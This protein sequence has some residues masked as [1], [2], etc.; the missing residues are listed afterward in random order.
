[1]TQDTG[2]RRE[3]E[4]AH[5]AAGASLHSQVDW[6]SINWKRVNHNVRHLQKRIVQAQQ[7]ELTSTA[8]PRPLQR[9]FKRLELLAAKVARAVLRGRGGSDVALLPERFQAVGNIN[10]VIP[11]VPAL[12]VLS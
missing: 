3:F 12:A 6:N 10:I 7:Q 2:I 5:R 8:A 11:I 4:T 9:T 1:M